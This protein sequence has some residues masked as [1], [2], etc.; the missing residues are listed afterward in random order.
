MGGVVR[1]MCWDRLG[2]AKEGWEAKVPVLHF[3][4]LPVCLFFRF[5]AGLI[6]NPGMISGRGGKVKGLITRTTSL[7]ANVLSREPGLKGGG[8]GAC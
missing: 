8:G 6:N 7:C 5:S 4:L 3:R 1:S 2:S